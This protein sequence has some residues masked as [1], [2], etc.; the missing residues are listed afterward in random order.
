MELSYVSILDL[1][2]THAGNRGPA[3]PL[4]WWFSLEI[5]LK[6]IPHIC[7]SIHGYK[8]REIV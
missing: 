4:Q 2:L 6:K 1:K 5:S 8:I 3:D 7:D